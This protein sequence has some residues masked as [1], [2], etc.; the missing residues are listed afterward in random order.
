VS[1]KR[2]ANVFEHPALLEFQARTNA[3]TIVDQQK[4]H[5]EEISRLHADYKAKLKDK[6]EEIDLR[7]KAIAYVA[8][9]RN[10]YRSWYTDLQELLENAVIEPKALPQEPTTLWFLIEAELFRRRCVDCKDVTC[11]GDC[12]AEVTA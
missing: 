8:K 4:H 9:E 10:Q 12:G 3:Q 5:A 2:I 6:N 7:D 1:D 11:P